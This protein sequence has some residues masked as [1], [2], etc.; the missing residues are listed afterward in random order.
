M[1]AEH[2]NQTS[3]AQTNFKKIKVT[4]RE[5]VG[6]TVA[7]WKVLQVLPFNEPELCE[8]WQVVRGVIFIGKTVNSPEIF[9]C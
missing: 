9:L 2:L 6:V 3:S 8:Q 5:E 4:L 7:T 1:Q